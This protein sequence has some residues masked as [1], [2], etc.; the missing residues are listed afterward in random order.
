MSKKHVFPFIKVTI[1]LVLTVLPACGG[2]RLGSVPLDWGIGRQAATPSGGGQNPTNQIVGRWE[3]RFKFQD[4]IVPF[5]VTNK[6]SGKNNITLPSGDKVSLDR[7]ETKGY[8][9]EVDLKGE[10]SIFYDEK[11]GT[12]IAIWTAVLPNGR[13]SDSALYISRFENG[14]Y[15]LRYSLASSDTDVYRL[16]YLGP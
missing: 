1:L 11:T 8:F 13:R 6:V 5:E 7:F 10:F 12:G 16:K 2:E 3:L 14:E 9:R 4:R 15:I